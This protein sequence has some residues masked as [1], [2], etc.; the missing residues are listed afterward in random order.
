M[1]LEPLFDLA[2]LRLSWT[3]TAL[4]APQHSLQCSPICLWW[5]ELQQIEYYR[6]QLARVE[7]LGG[8]FTA[9][10]RHIMSLP[11]EAGTATTPK[12]E[13]SGTGSSFK[14]VYN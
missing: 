5:I 10:F 14:N 9:A 7:A 6:R 13:E 12:I 11:I 2:Q 8:R 4:Y 3:F 1:G